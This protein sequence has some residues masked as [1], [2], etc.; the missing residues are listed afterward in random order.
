MTRSPFARRPAFALALLAALVTLFTAAP[1]AHA[2]STE[3]LKELL[4]GVETLAAPGTPSPLAAWSKEAWVVLAGSGG[5]GIRAPAIV[6][7]RAGS[8]RFVA[9]PHNGYFAGAALE[10]AGTARF[11][12]NAVRFCAGSKREPVV[13]ARNAELVALLEKQGVAARALGGA[14]LLQELKGVDVVIGLSSELAMEDVAPLEAWVRAGGGIIAGQCAWGWLQVSGKASLDENSLQRL[15]GRFGVAWT[16]GYLGKTG[17]DGFNT[18]RDP[19]R[20]THAEFAFDYLSKHTK[21]EA[22]KNDTPML[23]ASATVTAVAQVIPPDDTL[24]RPRLVSA[25]AKKAT[26]VNPTAEAPLGRL[27]GGDR[28]LLAFLIRESERLPAHEVKALAAAQSFPGAVPSD[29]PRTTQKRTI[30]TAR[31]RWHSTGLYAAPGEPITLRVPAAAVAAGLVLQVGAHTDLL[32]E[33]EE[34]RRVPKAF[35][36]RP[37]TALS[38]TI[39]TPLGGLIY[40]DVPDNCTLGALEVEISGGVEAPWFVLGRDDD[41][42]WAATLRSK[43]APWAELECDRIIVTVPSSAIRNLAAPTELMELWAKGADAMATLVGIPRARKSPERFVADVQISAG[44]MHSGY[45]IMTHLD[46]APA[47]SDPAEL[48]KGQW[49]LWHELGH[50][51]QEGDWTFE[52]TGEVTNNVLCVHVLE[53]VFGIPTRKGHDAL[54]GTVAKIPA[55]LAGGANAA[56]PDDATGPNYE[57]WKS[58][59]FLALQMYLQ[60]REQFGWEPYQKAFNDYRSLPRREKPRTDE[61]KRD[62]WLVTLSRATHRDLGPFFTTWGIPTSDAA[63]AAVADLLA[64]MPEGFP[65]K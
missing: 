58:D 53:T 43:P 22:V 45:P 1:R 29:A 23:Q 5:K 51:H 40:V 7:G 36:R 42:T 30:E 39:A 24:L 52:G 49:G 63:R 28:A 62:L 57:E 26:A 59:P 13:A 56:G 17:G 46:A 3:A 65:P 50:N 2:Q 47:M 16:E 18:E 61:A 15:F 44:Y 20:L 37:V 35:A 34:W 38:T 9:L 31:P 4:D 11:L 12:A 48:K 25:G 60:V 14:P 6:A 54:E 21:P 64:W 8:G 55:Y 33:Q 19:P 32:W 41:A 10:K 27:A